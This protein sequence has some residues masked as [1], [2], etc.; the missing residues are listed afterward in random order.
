MRGRERGRE[1]DVKRARGTSASHGC[2]ARD[3]RVQKL[4][5]TDMERRARRTLAKAPP[6]CPGEAVA[7]PARWGGPISG[8]GSCRDAEVAA[9]SAA[10][11]SRLTSSLPGH[12]PPA[13]ARPAPCQRGAARRLRG[14]AGRDHSGALLAGCREKPARARPAGRGKDRTQGRSAL[15]GAPKRRAEAWWIP[16]QARSFAARAR[17]PGLL[18]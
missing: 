12:R 13:C 4:W 5:R 7:T 3:S 9:G 6:S 18:R 15:R 10:D 11:A 17:A 1:K 14:P 16:R 8:L 2:R